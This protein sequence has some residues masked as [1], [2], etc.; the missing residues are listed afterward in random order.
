M[1][2]WLEQLWE[3]SQGLIETP[4]FSTSYQ[5]YYMNEDL[6]RY[7][8]Q[9]YSDDYLYVDCTYASP[10]GASNY[11]LYLFLLLLERKGVYWHL[12]CFIEDPLID[13]QIII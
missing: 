11:E 8:E 9:F 7:L 12:L 3:S 13:S 2:K 4:R 10:S 5:L 6:I 1:Y